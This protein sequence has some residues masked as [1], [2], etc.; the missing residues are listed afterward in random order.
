MTSEMLFTTSKTVSNEVPD[1]SLNYKVVI[2][3]IGGWQMQDDFERIWKEA[4]QSLRYLL[5]ETEEILENP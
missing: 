1:G 2:T 3:S 5:A 4:V